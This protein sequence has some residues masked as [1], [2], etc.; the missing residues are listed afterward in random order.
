MKKAVFQKAMENGMGR[1]VLELDTPQGLKS[2]KE[3]V[4]DGCLRNVTEVAQIDESR[5]EF[6][7][8]LVK[9]FK[10]DE[11]FLE[12]VLKLY[13]NTKNS[14][15][16]LFRQMTDF[17]WCFVN[18]GKIEIYDVLFGKL[19]ELKKLICST[20][21]ADNSLELFRIACWAFIEYDDFKGYVSAIR[22][23][24]EICLETSFENADFDDILFSCSDKFLHRR[25]LKELHLY[26]SRKMF[27]HFY[28]IL[29]QPQYNSPK[30]F[31]VP[32]KSE[33]AIPDVE[34]V[35]NHAMK[36]SE[37]KEGADLESVLF[38]C[39]QILLLHNELQTKRVP[40]ELLL[41]AYEN[42]PSAVVRSQ[43]LL[44]LGKK[45]MITPEIAAEC[46]HDCYKRTRSY[47]N[48]YYKGLLENK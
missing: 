31:S 2:F 9:K 41:F 27:N 38:V 26:T 12:P 42:S 8:T 17:L 6:L 4:R 3:I 21:G 23:I 28:R 29:R 15:K 25:I 24:D 35:Y 45:K 40:K 36:L 46:M 39:K 34:D 30:V 10:D 44:L 7:Y 14:D 20:E 33:M 5:G 18:E 19:S 43:V 1:C 16:G 47:I 37:M 32:R 48:Q 11:Y 22:A 13:I